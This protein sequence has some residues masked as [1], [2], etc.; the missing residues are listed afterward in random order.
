MQIGDIVHLHP[1]QASPGVYHAG[2]VVYIHPKRRF[3][4]AEF[5][6]TRMDGKILSYRESFYFPER[7]GAP[8]YTGTAMSDAERK[9]RDRIAHRKKKRKFRSGKI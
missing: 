6:F 3:Y 8:D 7:A 9:Q 4:T 2:T 1:S 5:S